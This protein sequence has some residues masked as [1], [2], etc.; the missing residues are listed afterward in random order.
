MEFSRDS[1]KPQRWMPLDC[2]KQLLDKRIERHQRDVC[3]LGFWVFSRAEWN[4]AV[5][6]SLSS[7]VELCWLT[8]ALFVSSPLIYYHCPLTNLWQQQC[9][10]QAG[11]WALRACKW[12]IQQL[13]P[14]LI[15]GLGPPYSTKRL[16]MFWT[17][18][19]ELLIRRA[20][21]RGLRMC[22]KAGT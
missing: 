14:L 12:Y 1:L 22:N 13:T 9:K 20:V 11:E 18:G 6:L 17:W 8:L 10:L 3:V 5:L 19:T 15:I 16:D 7:A 21:S 4:G 2:V